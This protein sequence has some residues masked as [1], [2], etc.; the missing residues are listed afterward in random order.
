MPDQDRRAFGYGEL[1]LY[2]KAGTLEAHIVTI[3]RAN[4][5]H[6]GAAYRKPGQAPPKPTP[7]EL[8]YDTTPEIS[9]AG[10]LGRYLTKVP[11]DFGSQVATFVEGL[12]HDAPILNHPE[13]IL[14]KT[15]RLIGADA[16]AEVHAPR[17]TLLPWAVT[18]DGREIATVTE[19]FNRK[20]L[21]ALAEQVRRRT[22]A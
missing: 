3:I 9:G 18:I 2:R 8:T 4:G 16:I 7:E 20:A 13:L 15:A 22:A 19:P 5:G 11:P 6:A 14:G 17:N 10:V 1:C 12:A 21:R